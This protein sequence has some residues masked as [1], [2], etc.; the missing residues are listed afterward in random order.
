MDNNAVQRIIL[1]E[2]DILLIRVPYSL[3]QDRQAVLGL[4]ANIKKK[5]QPRRNKIMIL[6]H[7]VEIGVIGSK[8]VKEYITNVDL[9]Q[10]WDE[11]GDAVDEI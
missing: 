8:E 4:Y 5:I 1:K 6:P 7:E 10:L 11:N 9:W 3:F 2:D